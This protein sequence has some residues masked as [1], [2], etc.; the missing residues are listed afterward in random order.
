[1]TSTDAPQ[2]PA[3]GPEPERARER[4]AHGEP[5]TAHASGTA[6]M[7]KG[8]RTRR[9]ILAAARRQ[10]AE[11]GFERATIRA[12]AAE[13][14]VDKASVIQYFGTKQGL[15]RESVD[16]EIPVAE[17]TT[18]DPG[19]S[20]ENYLRTMLGAWSKDPDSPMTALLRTSM[21][22]EDAAELLRRRVTEQAIDPVA[23]QLD[24]PDA[25]LR[26]ALVGAMMM[27]IAT[28]RYLL[29]MPDLAAAGETDVL[30]LA[31]PV[32]RALID[33]AAQSAGSQADTETGPGDDPGTS[34]DAATSTG[35]MD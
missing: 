7:R 35:P 23:A 13:A 14:D 3:G 6:G 21:T 18:D 15:F 8:E 1:M 24:D 33:P 16:W 26:A 2:G 17:L 31:V 22:S 9:R 32:L 4:R 19:E 20:V 11:V 34:A 28:H 10:F 25:R 29:R 12:I 5:R 27:G 30:R